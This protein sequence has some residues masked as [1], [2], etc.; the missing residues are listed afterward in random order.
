MFS[1]LM[2]YMHVSRNGMQ[3]SKFTVAWLFVERM[4]THAKGAMGCVM[5]GSLMGYVELH[6]GLLELC[7]VSQ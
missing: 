1:I 3:E 5:P 2:T 6:G 4:D 7:F